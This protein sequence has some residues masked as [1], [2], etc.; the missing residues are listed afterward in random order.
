MTGTKLSPTVPYLPSND[1]IT[2]FDGRHHNLAIMFYNYGHVIEV[3]AA[4]AAITSSHLLDSEF[5]DKQQKQPL[6]THTFS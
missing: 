2:R 1:E 5:K 6:L 3:L 4:S